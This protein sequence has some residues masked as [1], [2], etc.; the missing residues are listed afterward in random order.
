MDSWLGSTSFIIVSQ[1]NFWRMGLRKRIPM[2]S[3]LVWP[4]HIQPYCAGQR[5]FSR[6]P[7][8]GLG[9]ES[10]SLL[11]RPCPFLPFYS[12]SQEW[13]LLGN[14]PT[15]SWMVCEV[16]GAEMGSTHRSLVSSR[17]AHGQWGTEAWIYAT[18]VSSPLAL[19]RWRR[20]RLF[21]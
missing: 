3:S 8:L 13:R 17:L 2:F 11:C 9:A 19:A 4:W 7:G 14:A 15:G 21:S 20:T 5:E 10:S 18:N 1:R 6:V 16:D 12:S